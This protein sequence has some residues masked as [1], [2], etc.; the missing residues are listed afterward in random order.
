MTEQD[1]IRNLVNDALK[2]AGQTP[3]LD[4][5]D[6]DFDL[7]SVESEPLVTSQSKA[8]QDIAK[9]IEIQLSTVGVAK[10]SIAQLRGSIEDEITNALDLQPE[11]PSIHFKSEEFKDPIKR[12]QDFMSYLNRLKSVP[13]HSHRET[14]MVQIDSESDGVNAIWDHG[15]V[16]L[17]KPN[18]EHTYGSPQLAKDYDFV[19]LALDPEGKKSLIKQKTYKRNHLS[20]MNEMFDTISSIR[21]DPELLMVSNNK[22]L[23]FNGDLNSEKMQALI[24]FAVKR[25]LLPF[26]S[27]EVG[28]KTYISV[29]SKSITKVDNSLVKMQKKAKCSATPRALISGD[30]SYAKSFNVC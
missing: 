25:K 18:Q 27:S 7:G 6:K 23:R 3:K 9:R 16:R 20:S 14:S 11:A 26:K 15:V 13:L 22:I 30:G 2:E 21:K 4:A 17:M 24:G 29:D 1:E 12:S 28:A 8:W 19:I 10:Q 5:D